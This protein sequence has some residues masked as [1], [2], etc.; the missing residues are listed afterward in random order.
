MRLVLA[1]ASCFA[2][3]GC[4]IEDP[5]D[6]PYYGGGGGGWGSGWG[7]GGGS[8]EYGCASDAECGGGLTCTRTRECLDPALV[9]KVST[10]WTVRGQPASTSSCTGVPRLS[11]TFRSS[12]GEEFGYTPVPCDA[13]KHTVDKFPTRYTTV[14]LAADYDYEGGDSATFD[15][16]GNALLDLPY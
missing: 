3:G 1:L 10:S 15:A 9:R 14:Q 2:L 5:H 4:F 6:D 13:G 16:T 12:A 11:I 7:G 8:Y